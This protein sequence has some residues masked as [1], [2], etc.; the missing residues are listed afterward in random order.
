MGS[1]TK[2]KKD[3]IRP[4]VEASWARASCHN[5]LT[6]VLFMIA[7]IVF[8]EFGIPQPPQ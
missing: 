3:S 8:A 6:F 4:I 7:Y 2:G 5:V 1:L